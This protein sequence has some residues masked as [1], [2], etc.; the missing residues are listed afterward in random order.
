MRWLLCILA[1][2]WALPVAAD[3]EDE[4]YAART[5]IWRSGQ[6]HYETTYHRADGRTR[7]CGQIDPLK[8][9]YEGSCDPRR[10]DGRERMW[11]INESWDNDG[12]G[13]LGPSGTLPSHGRKAPTLSLPGP[14]KRV[15][16]PGEVTIE[17][18][19]LKKYEFLA[20]PGD[21]SSLVETI[22][23]DVESK[24]PVRFETR[25]THETA[26]TVTIYRHDPLI[27]IEPPHVDLEKR[28]AR[29][30]RQFL[31]SVESGDAACRE[32]MLSVVARG[33]T[34]SFQFDL[35]RFFHSHLSH[36]SGI[37]VPPDSVR[38]TFD[39]GGEMIVIGEQGWIKREKWEEVNQARDQVNWLMSEL[40]P[41]SDNVGAVQCLGKASIAGREYRVYD[42]DFYREGRSARVL[43][44]RRRLLVDAVT[45][46]PAQT[47]GLSS[48]G[49]GGWVEMRWYDPGLKVEPPPLGA[50]DPPPVRMRLMSQEEY[51]RAI[52]PE[53][54][55]HEI[56]RQ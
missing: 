45:G 19:T 28:R 5:S 50:G 6:F 32:E 13:W 20:W 53:L 47:T 21:R 4:A 31:D 35:R 3:C 9:E 34:A 2:L 23:I 11:I 24:L 27:R 44:G 56:L 1:C 52:N 54:F 17:E 38:S 46:L 55:V 36:L 26:D 29:S 30:M 25:S 51:R 40:S 15:T 39:L 42:F 49:A 7:V 12:F 37:F 18:R 10:V 14:F 43:E 8:A 33:R 16:C 41:T 48:G 22:F